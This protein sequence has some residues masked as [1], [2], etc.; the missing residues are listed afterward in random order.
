MIIEGFPS[1]TDEAEF[2]ATKGSIIINTP[3]P[4]FVMYI[5]TSYYLLI[6]MWI[7]TGLFPDATVILKVGDQD[8][9]SRILPPKMAIWRR[10]RDKRLAIRERKRQKRIKEWVKSLNILLECFTVVS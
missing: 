3:Y 8:V 5:I 6:A 2:M 4:H 1:T 9:V 7:I 10:K